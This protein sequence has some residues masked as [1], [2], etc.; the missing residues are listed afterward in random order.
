MAK[1]VVDFTIEEYAAKRP[2]WTERSILAG[3]HRDAPY[4]FAVGLKE[5]LDRDA[6]RP[7]IGL[8]QAK[9]SGLVTITHARRNKRIATLEFAG[10]NSS[11]FPKVEINQRG[12]PRLRFSLLGHPNKLMTDDLQKAADYITR[13]I[14]ISMAPGARRR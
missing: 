3:Y 2:S 10:A 4:E 5:I 13:V 12:V 6:R 14:A 9:R 8:K 11:G 7:V 1:T